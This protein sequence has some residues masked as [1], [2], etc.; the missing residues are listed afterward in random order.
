MPD[1]WIK[2][3][4]RGGAVCRNF[5]SNDNSM[6]RIC[7]SRLAGEC[8]SITKRKELKRSTD[9]LQMAEILSVGLHISLVM[10][11]STDKI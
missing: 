5:I 3:R 2:W 4:Q 7:Q 6:K 8:S 1:V 11:S 10:R 9:D